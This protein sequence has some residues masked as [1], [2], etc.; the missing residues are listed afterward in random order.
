M[1]L[2]P[3]EEMLTLIGG[4]LV[5]YFVYVLIARKNGKY[6]S[7]RDSTTPSLPASHVCDAP[8]ISHFELIFTQDFPSLLNAFTSNVMYV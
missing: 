2:Q 1:L 4:L 5:A 8:S 7:P 6:I 3:T